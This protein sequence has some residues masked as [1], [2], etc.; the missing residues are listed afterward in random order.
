M[1]QAVG[2]AATQRGRVPVLAAVQS[3]APYKKVVPA[4]RSNMR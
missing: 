1:K 4:L 3:F 2:V